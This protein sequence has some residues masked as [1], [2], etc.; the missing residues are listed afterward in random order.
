MKRKT[1]LITAA[2]VLLAAGAAVPALAIGT[3]IADVNAQLAAAGYRDIH[4]IERDDGLWQADVT[5]ADGSR[6]EVSIDLD[7][8]EIF[9]GRAGRP[10][11]DAGKALAQVAA[12][13]YRD[14]T[15]LELDGAV[16]DVEA[17]NGRGE[18]FDLRLGGHD[19][20]LLHSRRDRD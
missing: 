7:R 3:A 14:V 20:R 2:A 13:G 1:A 6:G 8:R 9:D 16:W 11:I 19:G 18:R 5:R 15:S 17:R 12:L 10:L 4:D